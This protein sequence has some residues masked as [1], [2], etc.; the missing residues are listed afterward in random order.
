MNILYDTLWVQTATSCVI[1]EF[2]D[3]IAMSLSTGQRHPAV[4]GKGCGDKEANTCPPAT[5]SCSVLGRLPRFL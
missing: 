5:N 2:P 1:S 4:A 3:I